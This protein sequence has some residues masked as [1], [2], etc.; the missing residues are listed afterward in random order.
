LAHGPRGVAASPTNPAQDQ[1]IPVSILPFQDESGT[2]APAEV[3][4]KIAQ[5]LQQKLNAASKN[6]L[7]QTL[8]TGPDPSS[9]G[10]MNE[11]QISALGKQQLYWFRFKPAKKVCG[12]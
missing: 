2:D 8:N 12:F 11:E 5:E 3:G 10:A 4:K 1:V 6:L 7:A 9:A